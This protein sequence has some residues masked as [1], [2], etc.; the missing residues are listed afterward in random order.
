MAVMVTSAG[1]VLLGMILR[2]PHTPLYHARALIA[3]QVHDG[4]DQTYL[5]YG[6]GMTTCTHF[7]SILLSSPPPAYRHLHG[8]V[9][10]FKSKLPYAV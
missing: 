8:L 2:C 10:L 1:T 4:N 6:A 7:D 3:W 5:G 9:S